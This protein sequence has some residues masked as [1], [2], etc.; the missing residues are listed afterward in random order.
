MSYPNEGTYVCYNR[1]ETVEQE[2]ALE[3]EK[4][5]VLGQTARNGC[6]VMAVGIF[7]QTNLSFMLTMSKQ[8]LAGI[9]MRYVYT[10]TGIYAFCLQSC[11]I[12]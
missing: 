7:V 12:I 9:M 11:K 2:N 1:T 3:D 10:Y 5:K 8:R 4:V 6:E